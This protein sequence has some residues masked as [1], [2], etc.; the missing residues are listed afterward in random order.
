MTGRCSWRHEKADF[1]R[2]GWRAGLSPDERAKLHEHLMDG[3]GEFD[4]VCR[5]H[6]IPYY[7]VA[8][9]LLGA[10]RHQG[11]IP[12]DDDVDI[13]LMRPDYE[14]FLS[15][16]ARELKSRYFLQTNKSDPEYFLCFAKIRISGTKIVE[17]SSIDCDIHSGVFID[18]LPFD[19][20]PDWRAMRWLHAGIC[21]LLNI[22]VLARGNYRD[23]SPLRNCVVRVL[24]AFLRP[25]PFPTLMSWLQAALQ[26][27]HNEE[28]RYVV[29]FSGMSYRRDCLPRRYF[30]E[31]IDLTFGGHAASAPAMWDEYL[32]DLYGDYMTPPP[33]DERGKGHAV[34]ELE[35]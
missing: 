6:D 4:R 31:S 18:I 20:V 7:L 8:G 5:A 12:W 22:M 1:G 15:V 2:P 24:R 28:S 9:S 23:L 33:E 13:A 14:R 3:F 27:S 26:L 16:A 30:R 25:I 11:I 34:V 35:L 21:R 10:V 29:M 19:N 17:A 32:T